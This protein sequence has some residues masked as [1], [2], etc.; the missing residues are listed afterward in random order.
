MNNGLWLWGAAHLGPANTGNFL[1]G[2]RV[3]QSGIHI[4]LFHGAERTWFAEQGAGKQPHAA[5]DAHEIEAA[6]LAHA[7]LGHYH[8]P[9][10]A[11]YHTY[12]GNPDPLAFGEDGVRGA[13]VA[14]ISPEGRIERERHRVAVTEVHDLELDVTGLTTQQQILNR[15]EAEASSLS[16][17]ARLTV[18]GEIA[19]TIDIQEGDLRDRLNSFEAVQI[20]FG[21]LRP[22][23]DMESIR[24]EPTVRG[25]FVRDVLDSD[26]AE[27]EKRRVVVTGLRALGR[28]YRPGGPLMRFESVKAYAF[29]PFRNESLELASGMNV[30]YGPNE[31]G[32]SSW[33]AA[34]YAGLCGMRRARGRASKNDAE[35]AELHK[36]WDSNTS[37]DV[38]AIIRLD[39][40]RRVELRHDLAGGVDSSARD[41]DLAGRDYSS[42]IM[43][44]GA[45]DGARWPRTRQALVRHDR[46]YPPGRHPWASQLSV[47]APR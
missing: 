12:P 7:F 19:S 30:V 8:R 16:G 21:D 26:L 45:P 22:T 13:I 2:F 28:P 15:L 34:L 18:R 25:Q 43:F 47:R 10:D 44:E 23:Y 14:T 35:F 4:A 11:E 1:H 5:F 40:G 27:D 31:A 42:E 39:D 32:K 41:V 36:P 9:K 20:V 33:H 24:Q 46:L 38:G 3:E 37:W 6:G 29:G 17:F